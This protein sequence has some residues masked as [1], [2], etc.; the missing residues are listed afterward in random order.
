M[1]SCVVCPLCCSFDHNFFL[2]LCVVVSF[3]WLIFTHTGWQANPKMRTLRSVKV[4]DKFSRS[5]CVHL[6][7][8]PLIFSGITCQGHVRKCRSWR[9]LCSSQAWDNSHMTTTGAWLVMCLHAS[10]DSRI[11][12]HTYDTRGLSYNVKKKM[13]HLENGMVSRNGSGNYPVLVEVTLKWG[14]QIVST[15]SEGAAS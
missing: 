6:H 7:S 10:A 3:F 11:L 8:F 1:R 2:R 15:I 4:S 14:Y 9:L 13:R 5:L 12:E